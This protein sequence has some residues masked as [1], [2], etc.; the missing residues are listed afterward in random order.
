MK[1]L[2]FFLLSTFLIAG[3]TIAYFSDVESA[4]AT[5]TSG[6]VDLEVWQNGWVSNPGKLID[7]E[8]KPCEYRETII[9]VRNN[10]SNPG[11][12]DIGI[13]NVRDSGGIFSEAEKEADPSNSIN[14]ISEVTYVGIW[15][16]CDSYVITVVEN[17]NKTV[18]EI[19]DEIFYLPEIQPNEV[20]LLHFTFHIN[21]TAGNEYQGDVIKF[22]L[23]L[24]LHQPDGS[25]YCCEETGWAISEN[26]TGFKQ[27]WGGYFE[28]VEDELEVPIYVGR[29]TNA[30]K[31]IVQKINDDWQITFI[32]SNGWTLLE[33]HLYAGDE[34][35]QKSAP[36]QFPYKHENVNSDTDVYT[37]KAA[38]YIAA[39]AVLIK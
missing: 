29:N 14:N 27:G 28:V 3:G 5:F 31:L 11:I 7:I 21:S 15:A 34:P 23:Q 17:D 18:R 36:G 30:G 20:C 32:A 39:H 25:N 4:P 13:T 6:D 26:F 12:L 9:K 19:E 16:E 35:P 38:R 10:G 1:T 22:D 33:T 24:S 8:A 37:I 2:Y